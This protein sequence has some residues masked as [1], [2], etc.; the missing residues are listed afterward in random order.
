MFHS[1]IAT[2]LYDMSGNV[3]EWCRLV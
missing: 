3:W 2:G 1:P